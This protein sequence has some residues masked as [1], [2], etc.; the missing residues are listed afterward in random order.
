MSRMLR[1]AQEAAERVRELL[2]HDGERYAGLGTRLRESAP[3]GVITI[4]RGSSD[5]AAN[6]AAYLIPVCTG[7]IVASLAPSLV[8]VLNAK[9]A[10]KGQLALA[11]SQGGRSPDLNAALQAA[12]D[13]GALT[14][15]IV[16]DVESPLAKRADFLLPQHAGA[17]GI[18]ATKSMLCSLSAIARVCAEWEN[19]AGLKSALDGLPDALRSAFEVGSKL[20]T[21]PLQKTRHIYTL[22]RG[23]GLSAALETALKL[24]ETCRWHSRR[25]VLDG[26]STAWAARNCRGRLSS[27]SLLRS[28][29]RDTTTR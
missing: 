26:G 5:H 3:S 20:D 27:W 11:I 28:R 2:T 17:E 6:Y 1:E 10:V 4:A 18:A 16:N 8:S 29:A 13:A 24:K 15:A 22:S 9:L 19:D 25:S 14:A 21:G 23:L 12:K 7:R